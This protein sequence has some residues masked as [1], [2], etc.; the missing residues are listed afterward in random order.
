MPSFRLAAGA[1]FALSLAVL[2]GCVN[3]DPAIFVAPTLAN[4]TAVVG[5]GV[6]GTALTGTFILELH[7]GARASG[8]S[9]VTIGEFSLVESN[10]STPIVSPLPNLSASPAFPVVVQPNST[11]SV[12]FTF[13]TGVNL[14]PA[15]DEAMICNSPGGLVVSGVLQ[16]S[17][18]DTATP[19]YSQAFQASGCPGG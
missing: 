4:P 3:T 11:A 15:A 7:L 5:S 18:Q 8:A 17:L 10:Q 2:G 9:T 13:G 12:D 6:L 1:A 16:D 14:L 19:V